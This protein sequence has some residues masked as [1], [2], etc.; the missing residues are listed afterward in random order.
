MKYFLSLMVALVAGLLAVPAVSFKPTLKQSRVRKGPVQMASGASAR[1][2][3][4]AVIIAAGLNSWS[5][6][7]AMAEG[8]VFFERKTYSAVLNPKDAQLADDASSNENVK[9]G[10]ASLT[11]YISSISS[12]RS[13]LVLFLLTNMHYIMH[14]PF[15]LIESLPLLSKQKKNSQVDIRKRLTEELNPCACI[16]PKFHRREY[17]QLP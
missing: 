11:K 16:Y 7:P 5:V 6:L 14:L 2:V 13:D 15:L 9:A 3:V 8:P 17:Q 10:K 1:S 4:S 12:I